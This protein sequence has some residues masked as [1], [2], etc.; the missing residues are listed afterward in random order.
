VHSNSPSPTP[1][2]NP[3][4]NPTPTPTVPELSWLVIV[5]LLL[6]LFSVALIV[7]HRKTTKLN[8]WPFPAMWYIHPPYNSL[9]VKKLLIMFNQGTCTK[10][11]LTVYD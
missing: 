7:R 2:L 5:P 4:P 8:Q 10:N 9:L 11:L 1:S 3:T 6:S